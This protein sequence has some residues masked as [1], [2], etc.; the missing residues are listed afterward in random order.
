MSV[1]LGITKAEIDK[2]A[3]DI[4]SSFQRAFNDTATLKLYLDATADADLVALG[5]TAQE[6]TLIKSAWA[7]LAQLGAIWTGTAALDTPKDFR[8][9]VRQIWGVGAF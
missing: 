4:T 8:T 9:F 3:G 2:R 6:V 5:Y 1:G 7:D